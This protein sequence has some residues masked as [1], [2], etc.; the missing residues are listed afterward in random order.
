MDH[1]DT[2]NNYYNHFDVDHHDTV[3]NNIYGNIHDD[4]FFLHEDKSFQIS[5][6]VHKRKHMPMNKK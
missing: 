4:K 3:D 5:R 1:D 6:E 2:V